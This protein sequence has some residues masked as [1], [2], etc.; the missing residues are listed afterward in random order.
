MSFI[1]EVSKIGK[2]TVVFNNYK[3]R[4]CY[5]VKSG[6]IVWR[7]LGKNCKASIRTDSKKTAI[8]TANET[9]TGPHPV[10]MRAMTPKRLSRGKEDSRTST[11]EPVV[12]SHATSARATHN[13]AP[14]ASPILQ[15]ELK[16]QCTDPN[17]PELMA[18]NNALKEQLAE[19]R[20]DRQ[21]ILDHSIESDKRLLEYTETVFLPPPSLKLLTNGLATQVVAPSETPTQFIEERIGPTTNDCGVQ[22]HL[23]SN[24]GEDLL[25]ESKDKSTTD[26]SGSLQI[27][28]EELQSRILLLEDKNLSLQKKYDI[29]NEEAKNMISTIRGFEEDIKAKNTQIAE[30]EEYLMKQQNKITNLRYSNKTEYANVLEYHRKYP[31]EKN[32]CLSERRLEEAHCRDREITMIKNKSKSHKA[33]NKEF[34]LTIQSSHKH[35]NPSTNYISLHN[36]FGILE[37]INPEERDFQTVSYNR[38]PKVKQHKKYNKTTFTPKYSNKRTTLSTTA[39]IGSKENIP[40]TQV[41][42]IGDSHVRRIASLMTE[43]ISERTNITGIC[44]PGAGLLSI[45]PS[46]TTT[47]DP[48]TNCLVL[49]AGTNDVSAGRENTIFQHFEETINRC[50]QTSRVMVCSLPTRHDL[51]PTSPIH[52]VVDRVNSYMEELCSRHEGVEWLDLGCISRRYY[53]THGLHLRAS[54][55]R[56]LAGLIVGRLSRRHGSQ[57]NPP[58]NV[59]T[60]PANSIPR[61]LSSGPI[62]LAYETFAEAVKQRSSSGGIQNGNSNEK[63]ISAVRK[64]NIFLGNPPQTSRLN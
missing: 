57:H 47:S 52:G 31:E 14:N 53:T 30:L 49:L 32:R 48:E 3:Y 23:I 38:N 44:K 6:E 45:A 55:K 39:K 21:A 42:V 10:T 2:D 58:I 43:R 37:N 62:T 36:S 41:S 54:G 19:L 15:Q 4:E 8:Y 51:P 18:E 61:A 46:S 7:C 28:I 35:S 64:T 11:P 60:A 34:P 22:C 26:E 13:Q 63:C 16:A 24:E 27:T 5:S 56:L 20:K 40:F 12:V 29:L 33:L 25:I 1:L 59:R 50:T 17:T 9:H